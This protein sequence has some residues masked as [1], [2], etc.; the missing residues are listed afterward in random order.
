MDISELIKS[1]ILVLDGAMGTLI[2]NKRLSEKEFR[3]NKFPN[4]SIDLQG[5]NDVL[6]LTQPEIIEAVHKEYLEAGADII[7]TNT[8]NAN[9]ISQADYGLEGFIYEI[10]FSAAKTAKKVADEYSKV[11]PYRTRFVAGDL[12]PTNR[13]AS[14]SPDVNDPSLRNITFDQLADTYYEQI[15]GLVD[16]GVDLILVETIFDTLN[17]KAALFAAQKYFEK[18]G[19]KLPIMVSVTITDKSGRT[20]SGQTLEAFYTSVNHADIF[21]IGLNCALGAA[22]LKPYV[23]ELSQI[24]NC[25]I[26]AHP[27][28]GLPNQFGEY[29]ESPDEMAKLIEDFLKEGLVNIVGG[30]C[31]TTPAHIKLISE[32]AKKFK[33][34]EIPE[35]N[36]YP[37]FSGLETLT[38]FPETNLVYIGERTNVAGSAVFKKCIAEER[39]DEALKI[40]RQQVESGALIIDVNMDD[41][42]IDAEKMIVKFLHLVASDPDITK[43]P[44]MID[45]SKWE[46][47]ESAL[48]CLQ[49][50]GIV[51]SISLKDGVDKFKEKASLINKY[52]AA[53]VVM[54]FDEIGQADSFERKIEV[55]ERSYK[56]LTQEVGILPHNIIFD[57]NVLAIATGMEEHDKFALD[58]IR[59]TK[60][61]KD[62]LHGALVSGGISNLSFSFR[63]NNEIREILHAS[64]LYHAIHAGLDMAIVNAGM[65]KVYNDIPKDVLEIV[66]DVILCRKPDATDKLI[67]FAEKIKNTDKAVTKE[68]EQ[69]WRKD[70]LENRISHSLIKGIVDYIDIDVEEAL[71]KYPN[72]VDIIEGSLMDAMNI[73][74]DMFGTGKMFLPQVVKS[75]RVMK[76]IVAILQ[77]HIEKSKK[78]A[79]PRAKILLATVRGD[80][81]DIGKNIV[82]VI[83]GCNNYEIIDLGVMVHSS[84]IIDAAKEYKVDIIGLSG[85]IT[86]S[87]EEMVNVAKEMELEGFKIPLLVGGATTSGIHTAI[88][89]A[90]NYS[91]PVIHVV[92][93]S[94][95]V[96]ACSNLLNPETRDSYVS[97]IKEGYENIKNQYFT[98]Q[99]SKKFLPLADARKNKLSI[100]WKETKIV[101]PSYL[102]YQVF[103]DYSLAEIAKYIDWSQ[104]FIQW[105]LKGKYP[106]IFDNT[107]Q[108]IVA[109]KFFEDAQVFLNEIIDKKILK[110][111]AV[112][113]FYAANS[114]ADDDIEL[115]RNPD[116]KSS[117]LYVVNT[118]RQQDE[119]QNNVP[120]YALSDFIAPKDS[121]LTDYIGTFA[122][123]CGLNIEDAVKPYE[124]KKDDYS[125]LMIKTLANRLVEAFSEL[126]HE[127]VRKKHW[128]YA[129]GENF[130][131]K[132]LFSESYAG[133]RPAPG[134]PACPDHT[135]KKALFDLMEIEKNAGITLT[136]NYA[137]SPLASVSG[138]YYAH[139]LSKYF[140]L[141][142]IGKDQLE[143]YAGR[144]RMM[145]DEIKKWLAI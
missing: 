57:P 87:L 136:E 56:I 17:C 103:E 94:R 53:M 131:L 62:N 45:S 85:L 128:G 55:C 82:S 74:G 126:M 14:I 67:E 2:Q 26:S 80:V 52:G 81:H 77:P 13:S 140:I 138:F 61:I 101:K 4:H 38:V 40:A 144:R 134:Y 22:Q 109:K 72:P 60:W 90:P 58:F 29:E 49:G 132:Q 16:G 9:A 99:Q 83:L 139:P 7:T 97:K 65:V 115:Y 12:G 92:D 5:N 33:P 50:K 143:N 20:L 27:N 105:R 117:V 78:A 59:A 145:V 39:F 141:G 32:V 110:A 8:F 102:G 35:I 88:K 1:R 124:F 73:V 106:E 119:K 116:D 122:L 31:G 75:A 71:K 118:L 111:N 108:G 121:G 19:R 76:A 86:P 43:V 95:S 48:K 123:T 130:D 104:F 41:A 15:R 112:V 100:D 3:G 89:I 135:Q 91:G 107:P 30:C 137:M 129:K 68:L 79:K 98:N 11:K 114:N 120:N 21:S 25:F 34:R 18:I 47:I 10:N 6:S 46:V 63:G 96:A 70:S 64:F 37:Q 133:I 142:K 24:S 51:N 54:A 84:T 93:A 125:I 127:Q 28:A 69:E 36:D 23:K 113:G 66:E 44:V 42:M